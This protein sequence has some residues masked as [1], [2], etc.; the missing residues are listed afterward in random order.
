VI[1]EAVVTP[2]S[3]I[4]YRFLKSTQAAAAN[5]GASGSGQNN[6]LPQE[7]VNINAAPPAPPA[8]IANTSAEHPPRHP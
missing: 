5:T 7:A 8:P 3:T 1:I 4:Q 2:Q 6:D